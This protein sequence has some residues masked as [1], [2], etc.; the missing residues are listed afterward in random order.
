MPHKPKRPC[1]HPGCPNLSDGVYCEQHRG[2]YARESAAAR[3]YDSQWQKARTRFL[4][5][6]PLCTECLRNNRI[7]PATVVD[8]IIPHR[9][10]ETL[11]W[12]ESNWQPLCKPC[13]DRKTGLGL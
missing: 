13:H 6:N 8:H 2:L 10:D 3:G 11:F 7:V 9:G 4:K 1:R 12:D 5:Q